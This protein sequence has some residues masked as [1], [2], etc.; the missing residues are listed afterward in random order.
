MSQKIEEVRKI[1]FT[2]KSTYIVSLP[3]RWVTSLGL[4]AGSQIVVSQQDN[5]LILTPKELDKPSTRN[6]EAAI[7]ISSNDHPDMIARA[8]VS[9]Y[10]AG[11]NY[12]KVRTRD[13]RITAQQRNAIKELTRKKLV[14]TEVIAESPNEIKLQILIS[15]PELSVEDA[16][17]RICLISAS[18]HDDA[19]QALKTLDKNLAQEIINLDD[20]V[21]RFSLYIIRQLKAAVQNEK[22]LRDIGLSSPR[23]CLGYRVIVK[24]VER[25]ADHA[26]KIAENV[27]HLKEKLGEKVFQKISEMSTFAKSVFDESIK[28]LF[29]KDY[30]LADNVVSKAKTIT[31]L[32]AETIRE[33][34]TEIKQTD[35]S[36]I[37]MMMESI[38]RTAEYASDIAEIVLNLNISQKIAT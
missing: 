25:I 2:G 23:D 34:L 14:G 8:I 38:R 1:Q 29:K 27:M 21:D 32:E 3:K 13:E 37:R 28:S 4:R 31:I 22:I 12:I 11:Y 19:I 35:I 33:I 5:S 26:T 15:Y 6:I 10:L 16:L 7:N 20:E 18:M 36:N 9:L 24:F 30:T 17:R